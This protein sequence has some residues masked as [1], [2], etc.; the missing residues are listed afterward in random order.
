MALAPSPGGSVASELDEDTSRELAAWLKDAGRRR[1]QPSKVSG[2]S[3]D[4][5]A[6]SEELIRYLEELTGRRIRSREDLHGC[7]GEM[8]V[9]GRIHKRQTLKEALLLLCLAAA[10]IQYYFWDVNLQIARLPATVVFVPVDMAKNPPPRNAA[11]RTRWNEILPA[12]DRQAGQT[13]HPDPAA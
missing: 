11:G 13:T 10:Y 4:V 9:S 5:A 7:F 6:S 12:R 1:W 2:T 3:A 8:Q